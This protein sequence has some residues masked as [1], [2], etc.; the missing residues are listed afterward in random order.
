MKKLWPSLLISGLLVSNSLHPLEA[1]NRNEIRQIRNIEILVPH[2][3]WQLDEFFQQLQKLNPN[4]NVQW[5]KVSDQREFSYFRG[6][7]ASFSILSLDVLADDFKYKIASF[8]QH[9]SWDVGVKHTILKSKSDKKANP[10]AVTQAVLL[11]PDWVKNLPV[12]NQA[13]SV[14]KGETLQL[15]SGNYRQPVIVDGNL[16]LNGD[17]FA[18]TE[19]QVSGN[20]TLHNQTIAGDNMELSGNVTLGK[21]SHA[22][23]ETVTTRGQL[24]LKSGSTLMVKDIIMDKDGDVIL[25][26]TADLILN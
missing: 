23:F 25:N 12:M 11:M 24:D 17:K 19:L 15:D 6:E 26:G 4:I 14:K 7:H 21:D 8:D 18:F 5:P 3:T 20:L 22:Q 16:T 13:V 10:Q 9:Y 2:G 1:L